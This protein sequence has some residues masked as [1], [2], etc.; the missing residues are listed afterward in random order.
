LT[1]VRKKEIKRVNTQEITLMENPF[2][3]E[4]HCCEE[5]CGNR[6]SLKE[7]ANP[8]DGKYY[9][10]KHHPLNCAGCF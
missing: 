8:K 7:A 2:N 3:P 1:K 9:C 4:Y 10:E 6:L 5:G